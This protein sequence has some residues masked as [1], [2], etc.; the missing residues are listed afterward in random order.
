MFG[1]QPPAN[2]RALLAAVVSGK[3]PGPSAIA[4]SFFQRWLGTPAW[5]PFVFDTTAGPPL[6][7][8]AYLFYFLQSLPGTGTPPV[9]ASTALSP[10]YQPVPDPSTYP[11]VP[12]DITSY[13]ATAAG[14]LQQ[15]VWNDFTIAWANPG[16]G[17]GATSAWVKKWKVMEDIPDPSNPNARI[18]TAA[19][20]CRVDALLYAQQ[21]CWFVIPGAGFATVPE[22]DQA[23]GPPADNINQ[24]IDTADERARAR[25]LLRYN[26][27]ITVN[28]MITENFTAPV[29]VVREWTDKWS[30]PGSGPNGTLPSITYNFDSSVRAARDWDPGGAGVHTPPDVRRSTDSANLPRLPLLPVCPDLVYY[31]ETM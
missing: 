16:I 6:P 11:R 31:G 19:V 3:E 12:W 4:M 23:A 10:R 13:L 5:V 24:Q 26:Y 25:M 14:R 9:N 15:G 20:H 2:A 29:D 21:G 28:G 18:P 7:T 30:Y 27:D 22:I 8:S 1:E 17:A